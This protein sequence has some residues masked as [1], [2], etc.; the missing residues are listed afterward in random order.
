MNQAIYDLYGK[1]DYMIAD[2]TNIDSDL[3]DAIVQKQSL[4][5]LFQELNRFLNREKGIQAAYDI[6][7]ISSH[8]GRTLR[9]QD[10]LQASANKC[11]TKLLLKLN[12]SIAKQVKEVKLSEYFSGLLLESNDATELAEFVRTFPIVKDPNLNN[13]CLLKSKP[14]NLEQLLAQGYCN[15]VVVNVD[16]ISKSNK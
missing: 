14:D 16:F 9:T 3:W 7:Q 11:H 15:R 10:I 2:Y 5:R 12:D 6:D 8:D 1:V 4:P 13:I